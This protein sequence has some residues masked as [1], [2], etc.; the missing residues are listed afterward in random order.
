MCT[1]SVIYTFIDPIE[2]SPPIEVQAFCSLIIW[3]NVPGVQCGDIMGYRLKLTNPTTMR[4]IVREVDNLGTAYV[5]TEDDTEYKQVESQ[6]QVFQMTQGK[7]TV[8]PH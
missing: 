7:A 2:P 6:V 1:V 3:R 8:E 5:L 4:E